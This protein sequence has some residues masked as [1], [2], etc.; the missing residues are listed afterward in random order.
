MRL[1]HRFKIDGP[2]IGAARSVSGH[3]EFGSTQD[4]EKGAA[5]GQAH[6]NRRLDRSLMD[7]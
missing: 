5:D 7:N 6:E 2:I 4:G 3:P 1:R